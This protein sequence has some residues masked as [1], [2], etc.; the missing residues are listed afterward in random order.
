MS[1]AHP[2][3][4]SCALKDI[5]YLHSTIH[6]MS[7]LSFGAHSHQLNNLVDWNRTLG[8]F[9]ASFCQQEIEI[10][11]TQLVLRAADVVKNPI[12]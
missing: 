8:F 11:L 12:Q 6:S 2:H 7:D 5:A 1:S 9:N 10:C 3:Y 4:T